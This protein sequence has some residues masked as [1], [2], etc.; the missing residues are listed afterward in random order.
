MQ[1]PK[2][3]RHKV[4]VLTVPLRSISVA[5][6]LLGGSVTIMRPTQKRRSPAG[7]REKLKAWLLHFAGNNAVVSCL[8]ATADLTHRFVASRSI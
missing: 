7:G 8:M 1:D 4:L 3:F 5:E 6:L 2:V